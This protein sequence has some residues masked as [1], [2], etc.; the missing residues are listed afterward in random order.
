MATWVDGEA[1]PDEAIEYEFQRLQKLYS[2]YISRE[3]ME[4][5]KDKL[6]EKAKAQA[7][8]AK[9]LMMEAR[10]LNIEAPEADVDK[11]LEKMIDHAGG[12]EKFEKILARQNLTREQVREQIREGRRVDLLVERITADVP[13]PDEK[14][15]RAHFEAHREEFRIPAQAQA[16]H[17]LVK[18]S[19]DSEADQAVAGSCLQAVKS[20]VENGAE[21]SD[22]AAA[23][24]ECPSG[25]SSGG[26]LGWVAQGSMLPQIDETLFSMEVGAVSD[27]VETPLGLH[28][29]KKTDQTDSRQP[30][31]DEVR[32]KIRDFLR[33]AYRGEI[34]SRH[35]NELREKADIKED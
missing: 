33:H 15:M 30:E 32:D 8:G 1:I 21:F 4:K 19:S 9:L 17:V 35:V 24:S 29:L 23:H 3:Q 34:I 7:V 6:W 10:D 26:S 12:P 20:R 5:Q 31:F 14:A 27:V 25:R 18:P 16:Q 22:E 13:D 28:I 2:E 11:R